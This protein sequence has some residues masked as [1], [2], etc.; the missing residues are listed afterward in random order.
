MDESMQ[1]R[2]HQHFK[3]GYSKHTHFMRHMETHV[4]DVGN[5]SVL[6]V[7]IHISVMCGWCLC[8]SRFSSECVLFSAPKI[9]RQ[10]RTAV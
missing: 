5:T 4:N 2:E 3:A 10:Y 1:A 9:Y 7:Y 8:G 6:S